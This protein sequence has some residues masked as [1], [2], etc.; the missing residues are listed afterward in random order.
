MTETLIVSH[1]G[2]SEG[3]PPVTD[4]EEEQLREEF[5]FVL[6]TSNKRNNDNSL[7][8]HDG[9]GHTLCTSPT[10]N[11]RV[12]TKFS[13]FPRGYREVCR[14]CAQIW[15]HTSNQSVSIERVAAELDLGNVPYRAEI[16]GGDVVFY[17]V[18]D[19]LD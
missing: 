8:L 5:T 19:S 13:V 12:E 17:Y 18:D 16:E 10:K 7:H 4:E 1:T 15:R 2:D 11:E 6:T 14:H 9:G 3:I